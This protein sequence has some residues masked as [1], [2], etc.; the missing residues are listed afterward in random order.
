METFKIS[1]L[2]MLDIYIYIYIYIYMKVQIHDKV[3]KI[4]LKEFV[5]LHQS[6]VID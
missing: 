5:N 2:D 1:M 6:L 4:S 3:F